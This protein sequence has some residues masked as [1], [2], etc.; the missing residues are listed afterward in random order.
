[1]SLSD[2]NI[3]L[4]SNGQHN[5]VLSFYN[6]QWLQEY[7]SRLCFLIHLFIFVYY[8]FIFLLG[9]SS[10]PQLN[11]FESYL[12]YVACLLNLSFDVLICD[13]KAL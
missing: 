3:Y 5:L 10:I 11:T 1:M 7:E 4:Y 13:V 2:R 12:G 6:L 8:L 9:G